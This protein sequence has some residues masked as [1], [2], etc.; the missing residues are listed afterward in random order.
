MNSDDGNNSNNITNDINNSSCKNIHYYH[1]LSTYYFPYIVPTSLYVISL[2]LHK[3]HARYFIDV[4][5][6]A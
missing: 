2:N 5:T 3:N 6:E 1:L 4:K